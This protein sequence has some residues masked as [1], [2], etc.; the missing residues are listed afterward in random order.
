MEAESHASVCARI[1]RPRACT[2]RSQSA[3][4]TPYHPL[5]SMARDSR[6]AGVHHPADFF[7]PPLVPTSSLVRALPVKKGQLSPSLPEKRHFP[8]LPF[9]LCFLHFFL[10]F[11]ITFPFSPSLKTITHAHTHTPLSLSLFS[12]SLTHKHAHTHIRALVL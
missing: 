4:T 10:P 1:D 5:S 8:S 11:S 9:P 12:H 7:F 6:E 3:C 2:Q